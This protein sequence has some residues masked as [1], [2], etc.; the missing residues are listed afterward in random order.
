[1]RD[2]YMTQKLSILGAGPF[3]T[4]FAT[5]LANNGHEVKIWCYEK[6][7][8]QDIN[9]SHENKKYLPGVILDPKIKATTDLQEAIQN[10]PYVFEAIP[11]S[12][13]RGVLTKAKDFFAHDQ[14]LVALSKGLEQ[15]TLFLPTQIIDD[16]FNNQIEKAVIAGPNFAAEIT[17]KYCTASV[18]GSDNKDVLSALTKLLQ[19]SYFKCF[20]TKDFIGIQVGGALKNI[21]ALSYGIFSEFSKE[22]TNFLAYVLTQGLEEMGKTAVCLGGQKETVY[23]LSGFG[24]LVLTTTGQLSR[25]L[26]AGKLIAK[27]KKLDEISAELGTLPEG[28]T[29]SGAIYELIQKMNLKLPLCKG[30]YEVVF[31]NKSLDDFFKELW[32]GS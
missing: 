2:L 24:D 19:N 29:T 8:A 10:S 12:F 18:I 11:L 23:G 26:K 17:K 7:V 3:G 4:A 30:T 13:L 15:N 6:E 32:T 1:M 25:N 31:K 22:H 21:I 20:Y 14:V 28:I 5:L 9:M 27:G 16:I